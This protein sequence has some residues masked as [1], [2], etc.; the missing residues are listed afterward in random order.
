MISGYKYEIM[1]MV[2]INILC[3]M[4]NTCHIYISMIYIFFIVIAYFQFYNF[5]T[6]SYDL[7][8]L[9]KWF[10]MFNSDVQKL[11]QKLQLIKFNNG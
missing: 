9:Y 7:V 10:N 1:K 3:D 11:S 2:G 8:L 5:F 4:K 6:N